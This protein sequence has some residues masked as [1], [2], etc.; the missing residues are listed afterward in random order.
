MNVQ[1]K[2][3]PASRKD[4][5]WLSSSCALCYG[6][7]TIRAH[8]VD[9]VV[10]KVEG[11]PDS[12]VGKGKLCGKGVSGIMSQYDPNRLTKP[13]R[14]TN[15]KKGLNE[16]P[17]FKEISWEEALDEIATVL[18][19]IRAEDPRKLIVQRTTTVTASR[20]PSRPSPPPSAPPISRSRA[21]GCI[22]ATAPI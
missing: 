21:A 3:A 7:C 5:V 4:D 15:P 2:P 17:R 18:K 8:R 1:A 19:K 11:N 9:G 12:V 14:R 6:S 13:L 16:D 22:A 20:T 10:I